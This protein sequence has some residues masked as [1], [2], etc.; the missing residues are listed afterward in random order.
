MVPVVPIYLLK[1][2]IVELYERPWVYITGDNGRQRRFR[3][4]PDPK[5]IRSALES[6]LMAMFIPPVS[7]AVWFGIISFC[8]ICYLTAFG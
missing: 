8:V 1:F 5:A 4:K 3:K 6:V 2:G 7:L